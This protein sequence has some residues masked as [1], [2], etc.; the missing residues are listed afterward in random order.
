MVE[1]LAPAECFIDG[2]RVAATGARHLIIDPFTEAPMGAVHDADDDVVDRA[3]TSARRAHA[4][5]RDVPVDTRAALL[6]RVAESLEGEESSIAGLVTREMGMPISL[7]RITQ[8]QLPGR[9]LRATAEVA[10][11]S[12]PWREESAD[13]VLL[14]SGSG[15]VG[16]ITPWNMPVH[17]IIAK[18]SAA[19]V[20][21]C[22]VVLKASEQTPYDALRIAEMFAVAGAPDGLFNVVTGAGTTTGAALAGHR[23]LSRLSFTGSVRAGRAVAALA[24]STLTRT[25]L[26]L[27]GKSP[28]VL[29][30][31]ADLDRA[32]PAALGSGLVNSGQACNATTRLVVP[33]ASFDD[34][35]DRIRAAAKTYVLG[36]PT[37]ADTTHGPLVTASAQRAVLGRIGQAL[38][39]G[40]RLVTGTGAA[41]RAADTGYFID[42]T[43]IV[44]LPETAAAVREEIFGPVVVVQTYSDVDD[45]VRIANDSVYGLSAEVWS[46]DEDRAQE[47]AARLSV[48][49]VKING[50]RTRDRVLVPF[51]GMR[52]SGYG[53]ELGVMGIDEFTDVTAVLS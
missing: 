6:E 17:Q 34:V 40:G 36:D 11:A 21:G 2:E 18:V 25:A 35:V 28:A 33:A 39:D 8:A 3:V 10:R 1:P 9:V 47:T 15:V 45:A 32:V 12:F 30:P 23:E 31:D 48:G 50:V 14:R 38:A 4:S 44:D 29:L 43:V 26:E 22:A 49:Q 46:A 51:G 13:A 42:P 53:R 27:G 5:W 41:S 52:D 16:A 37:D 24:A 20:A 19:V 7:A